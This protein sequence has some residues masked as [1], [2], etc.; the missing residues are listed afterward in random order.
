MR[1]RVIV[2][3]EL[4]HPVNRGTLSFSAV[5]MENSSLLF[6]VVIVGAHGMTRR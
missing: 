6:V 1:I 4:A 2:E 5:F 3:A